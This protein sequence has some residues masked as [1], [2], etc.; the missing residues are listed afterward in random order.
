MVI[1]FHQ[2]PKSLKIQGLHLGFNMNFKRRI[3]WRKWLGVA[4]WIAL[5]YFIGR[6]EQLSRMAR[7]LE[8][9]LAGDQR[10]IVPVRVRTTVAPVLVHRQPP[11][12][13]SAP[14][15]H[16]WNQFSH[17]EGRFS[18]MIPSVPVEQSTEG[19]GQQFS[20]KTAN[21][22]YSFSYATNFPGAELIT[23]RGKQ[24]IMERTA[25]NFDFEDFTVIGR[26]SFGLNGVP[27]VEIHLRHKDPN[28]PIMI[29]RKML[30]DDRMYTF[31]AATHFPQNAQ[32]F[33]S[34][35]RIH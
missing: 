27:G 33:L 3:E 28:A 18:V 4:G 19:D 2:L 30:L 21:E 26:R 6:P 17:P 23:E 10:Y 8:N 12:I 31:S 9:H 22:F 29:M 25:D 16:S 24:T 14:Q 35:F 34:S 1:R 13:A 7:S 20:V 5:G 32:T 11:I 15:A